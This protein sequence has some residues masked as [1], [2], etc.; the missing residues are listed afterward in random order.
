MGWGGKGAKFRTGV[1]LSS[2]TTGGSTPKGKEQREASR[3]RRKTP[4]HSYDL[5]K[6]ENI[7]VIPFNPIG[8]GNHGILPTERIF[9]IQE[10]GKVPLYFRRTEKEKAV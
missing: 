9:L 5:M 4:I 2:I 10:K 6:K 7:P 8:I 3:T 1:L